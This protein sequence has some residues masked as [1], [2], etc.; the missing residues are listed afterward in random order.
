MKDER[1]SD[2]PRPAHDLEARGRRRNAA[3]DLARSVGRENQ[4]PEDFKVDNGSR[5]ALLPLARDG[6]SH[7]DKGCARQQRLPLDAVIGESGFRS[8][9]ELRSPFQRIGACPTADQRMTRA[10]TE[11]ARRLGRFAVTEGDAAGIRRQAHACARV[12]TESARRIDWGASGHKL[13]CDALERIGLGL[14]PLLVDRLSANAAASTCSIVSEMMPAQHRARPDFQ[15]DPL[16][17]SDGA[18]DAL[19]EHDGFANVAPPVAAS[20]EGPGTIAPATVE[21]KGAELLDGARSDR[22]LR[23]GPL[24][25]SMRGV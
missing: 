22:F 15:K 25:G 24:A 10:L 7:L 20:N 19:L 6:E 1:R 8:R 3:Y 21:K 13:H 18:F 9:T 17:E 2:E 12:R 14:I 4:G 5:V 11:G 23:S 16:A